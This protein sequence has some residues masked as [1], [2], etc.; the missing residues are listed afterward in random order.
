MWA[1]VFSDQFAK[2]FLCNKAQ[3][4]KKQ[5]HSTRMEKAIKEVLK[6]IA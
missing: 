1:L 2:A 6:S 3:Y 4:I 5:Y